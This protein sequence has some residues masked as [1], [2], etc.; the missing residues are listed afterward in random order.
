MAECQLSLKRYAAAIASTE[1]AMKETAHPVVREQLRYTH[2]Q[3]RIQSGDR[4]GIAEANAAR[5][6]LAKHGEEVPKL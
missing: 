4:G 6:E 5:A 2:A 1:R 3:A